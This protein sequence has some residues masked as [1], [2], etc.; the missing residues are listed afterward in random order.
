MVAKDNAIKTNYVK[1]KSSNMQQ[2]SKCKLC[3]ERD[4]TVNRIGSECSN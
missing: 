1:A 2:N 4:E 3:V